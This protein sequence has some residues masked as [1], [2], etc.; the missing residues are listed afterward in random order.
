MSQVLGR[1]AA[2]L[3]AI[4][5]VSACSPVISPPSPLAGLPAA[6]WANLRKAIAELKREAAVSGQFGIDLESCRPE[7]WRDQIRRADFP[8]TVGLP[9]YFAFLGVA[10]PRQLPG[11]SWDCVPLWAVLF[12]GQPDGSFRAEVIDREAHRDR[13]DFYLLRDLRDR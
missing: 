6:D 8:G 12:H 7:P 3:L 1:L 2:C 11:G 9:V 13:S 4:S 5:V 10:E